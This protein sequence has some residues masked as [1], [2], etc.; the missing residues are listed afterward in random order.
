MDV[1]E[2]IASGSGVGGNVNNAAP[3]PA[4]ENS[5]ENGGLG[6]GFMADGDGAAVAAASQP[7]MMSDASQHLP[8]RIK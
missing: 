5:L 7:L 6:L 2:D 8:V 4:T 3:P 1:V